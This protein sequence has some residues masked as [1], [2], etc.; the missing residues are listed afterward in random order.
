MKK[1]VCMKLNTNCRIRALNAPLH[2]IIENLK[3]ITMKHFCKYLIDNKKL[4]F[5]ISNSKDSFNI[6]LWHKDITVFWYRISHTSRY[7][8]FE[9]LG[10]N[11]IYFKR[12]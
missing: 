6:I 7:F 1:M 5:E 2:L 12:K 4:L 8:E 11:L 3:Y 10:K 9:I